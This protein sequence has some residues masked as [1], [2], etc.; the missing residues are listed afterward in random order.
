VCDES[1][2]NRLY[3]VEAIAF[4]K[5]LELILTVASFQIPL[6]SDHFHFRGSHVLMGFGKKLLTSTGDWY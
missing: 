1:G 6:L 3:V 5:C 2:I 4:Q